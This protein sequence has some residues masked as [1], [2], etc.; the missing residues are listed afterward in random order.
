MSKKILF[1]ANIFGNWNGG[2]YYVRSMIYALLQYK[3][4]KQLEIY[5]LFSEKDKEIF[6]QFKKHTNVKLIMET[7]N[8]FS[9]FKKKA[10][11]TF[12]S[13][14]GKQ[15]IWELSDG[16]IEKYGIDSV[17]PMIKIDTK[18][19]QKGIGWLPDFQH[20]YFPEYFING[21]LEQREEEYKLI[22]D[23]CDKIIVSSVS[24]KE[25]FSKAYPS[26]MGKIYV[27]PFVSV[28]E[29]LSFDEKMIST[30][31]EKYRIKSNYFMVCNQTWKHKN[32][33]LL[34]E[35]VKY[36][37]HKFNENIL[38]ICTGLIEDTR[39][40]EYAKQ[41]KECI[42]SSNMEDNIKFLGMI[43]KKEQIELM[44]GSLAVIQ[45]SL[46]EGW[47]TVV[48]D[49]KTLRKKILLSDID[50]HYEQCNKDCE[51]F[52]RNN[53]T[54][55]GMLMHQYWN[56][57]ENIKIQSQYDYKVQAQKYGEILYRAIIEC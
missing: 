9:L 11:K 12:Y 19:V 50:V 25:D 17:F 26:Y 18:Y 53:F 42:A 7:N 56:N 5:I 28:V 44:K 3:E 29:N 31:K 55:L 8:I 45:P 15:S 16:I 34:F 54:E 27:I 48:E 20:L 23:N 43:P 4:S 40:L 49:A 22:V 10:R 46:F 13:M 36:V 14:S 30:V 21:S 6:E 38:V 32:H 33:L 41:L 39:D 57:A 2:L 52:H 37:R 35:A 51:F 47:G 24:V 1:L